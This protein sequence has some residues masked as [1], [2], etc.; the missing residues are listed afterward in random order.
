MGAELVEILPDTNTATSI[1]IHDEMPY[2]REFQAMA[3]TAPFQQTGTYTL[4]MTPGVTG[5]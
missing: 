1:C 3:A 4:L 2:S 5:C